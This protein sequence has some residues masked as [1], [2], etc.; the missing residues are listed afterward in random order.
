MCWRPRDSTAQLAMA[1]R[2]QV[3]LQAA[4]HEPADADTAPHVGENDSKGFVQSRS[5]LTCTHI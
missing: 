5:C 2:R 1:G 4:R 3:Y